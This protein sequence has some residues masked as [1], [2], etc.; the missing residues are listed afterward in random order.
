VVQL[1]NQQNAAEEKKAAELVESSLI[2]LACLGLGTIVTV[3]LFGYLISRSISEPLGRTVELIEAVT[4]G[5]I[6]LSIERD[7]KDESGKISAAASSMIRTLIGLAQEIS[8]VIVAVKDRQLDQRG[9]AGKF[10]GIYAELIKGFN[11]V[12]DTIQELH[13][14]AKRQRDEVM[15]FLNEGA[16]VLYKVAARDLT[17]R[18]KGN[19]KG[20]YGKIKDALNLTTTNLNEA[21]TQVAKASEQ[22]F[23]T[24]AQISAGSQTLS[25]EASEQASSLE[26]VSSSLQGVASMTAQNA[27]N[28]KEARS[29]SKEA[30]NSVEDG[31]LSM[32]SLS[33]AI[34]LIKTSSDA[35]ARIIKTIDEIA[36]Q[37]NLLA[38][39][40]AVEAAR[41]GEAG[42]GFAVVAEEVRNLALRSAEAA[43][44]TSNLI[45]E[46]TKNSERT[47]S[48]NQRSS[49]KGQLCHS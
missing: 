30:E 15:Q 26:E 8:R 2:I 13:D 42:K 1:T 31:V 37:T 39:N 25:Q 6:S 17:V 22:V 14:E 33:E 3:I 40:A 19:Y 12:M 41:A 34:G 18:V 47:V 29:I 21:L 38:L 9:E 43:K 28:A 35:T 27:K 49:K 4:A 48:L 10:R 45:Q 16:S 46:S 36:F 24:A 32:M 11:E 5:D 23:S 20:E 44:N 7:S